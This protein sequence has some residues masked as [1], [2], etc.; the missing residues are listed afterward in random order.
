MRALKFIFFVLAIIPISMEGSKTARHLP[1]MPYSY[2]WGIFSL[3]LG[4][5][6]EIPVHR[7]CHSEDIEYQ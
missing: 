1:K 5:H 6:F 3:K 4:L 2:L 7:D